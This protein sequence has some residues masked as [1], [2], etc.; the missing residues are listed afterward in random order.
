MNT[1][2]LVALVIAFAVVGL[3]GAASAQDGPGSSYTGYISYDSFQIIDTEEPTALDIDSGA[4]FRLDID[5]FDTNY[6]VNDNY[7]DDEDFIAEPGGV[8]PVGA[9]VYNMMSASP[10]WFY[11]EGVEHQVAT[12]GGSATITINTKDSEDSEPEMAAEITSDQSLWYS[13]SFSGYFINVED[14]GMAG[15]YGLLSDGLDFD[16]PGVADDCGNLILKSDSSGQ[17]ATLGWGGAKITEG[18]FAFSAYEGVVAELEGVPL[19]EAN[20]DVY[21][22]AASSSSFEGTVGDWGSISTGTTS[23]EIV[24][25]ETGWYADNLDD[26]CIDP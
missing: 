15:A 7:K 14:K 13:G 17:G 22:G 5:H 12:Q 11:S 24:F 2:I 25:V 23:A 21:G 9:G 20:F 8:V 3:T 16:D 10:E 26:F 6:G 18:T 4:C 1:K 19:G